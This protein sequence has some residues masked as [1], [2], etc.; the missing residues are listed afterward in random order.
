MFPGDSEG[1]QLL[2][3]SS[4]LGTPSKEELG[5]LSK[6]IEQSHLSLFTKIGNLPRVNLVNIFM[7]TGYSEHE[8]NEAADLIWRMVAWVPHHRI[9]AREAME[10]PFLRDTPLGL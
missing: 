8:K 1:L 2:E 5:E 3:H 4:L 7:H 9:S 10:H 6:L